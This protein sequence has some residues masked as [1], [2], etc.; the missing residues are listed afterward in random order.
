MTRNRQYNF[1]ENVDCVPGMAA[2]KPASID[3]IVT[4][5]PFAIDFKAKRANYN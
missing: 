4:D 2:M 3:V 1:I 5:I